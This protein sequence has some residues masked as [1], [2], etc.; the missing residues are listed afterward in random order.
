MYGIA[1]AY[2]E[3]MLEYVDND[4]SLIEYMAI[5]E[6]SIGNVSKSCSFAVKACSMGSCNLIN[7]Y[8]KDK[9]CFDDSKN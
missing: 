4:T 7:K 5:N 6:K 3:N 1:Q 8:R 2:F 9:F